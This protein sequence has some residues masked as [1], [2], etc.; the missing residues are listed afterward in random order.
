MKTF[1]KS[2]PT[3]DYNPQRLYNY[4]IWLLSRKSYTS[5]E[6]IEKMSNYQDDMS[7][8]ISVIDKL[9][10]YKYID[11]DEFL[12]RFIT[13]NIKKLGL[14]KIEQKLIQKGFSQKD[15]KEKLQ[16]IHQ[17]ENSSNDDEDVQLTLAFDLLIKK[18]KVFQS[19]FYP[20][21]CSFLSSRGF[22]F[23]IIKKSIDKFKSI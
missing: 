13:Y 5:F 8:I 9:K 12:S 20:K 17:E 23:A 6:L 16:I 19:D 22:S 10:E 7:M 15:I 4:T 2:T 14:R 1:N 11:D 3:K 21:Y 18:F